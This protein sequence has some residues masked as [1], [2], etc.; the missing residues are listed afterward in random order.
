MLTGD[1]RPPPPRPSP[2][3]TRWAVFQ[4][5]ANNR[6]IAPTSQSL[7]ASLCTVPGDALRP[8]GQEGAELRLDS[9]EGPGQKVSFKTLGFINDG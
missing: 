4:I 8:H 5:W 2:S 1:G 3:P 9:R 7:A 6:T